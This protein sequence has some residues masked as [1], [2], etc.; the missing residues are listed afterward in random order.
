[1]VKTDLLSPAAVA[2]Q[3]RVSTSTAKRWMKRGEIETVR[4][5]RGWLFADARAVRAFRRRRRTRTR[6]VIPR[7]PR[8]ADA[9]VPVER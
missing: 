7:P 1:M 8:A 9:A 5:G 2:R 6:T 3:L 4:D